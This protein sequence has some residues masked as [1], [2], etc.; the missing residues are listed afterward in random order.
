MFIEQFVNMFTIYPRKLLLVFS[1]WSSSWHTR[2]TDNLKW[3]HRQCNRLSFLESI[4]NLLYCLVRCTRKVSSINFI[5]LNECVGSW[6]CIV[7]SK[8]KAWKCDHN[9][10]SFVFHWCG[11]TGQVQR[12]DLFDFR[13]ITFCDAFEWPEALYNII[14]SSLDD[15]IFIR[16]PN[17]CIEFPLANYIP[18]HELHTTEYQFKQ[19]FGWRTIWILYEWLYKHDIWLDCK[20]CI[21]IWTVSPLKC[22]CLCS[23]FS[24]FRTRLFSK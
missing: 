1:I 2:W 22:V 24:S 8:S 16:Q 12:F 14:K 17:G 3:C 9:C 11:R 15:N 19:I 18:A 7:S 10:F 6:N 13:P 5:D 4:F 23:P 20:P 21:A